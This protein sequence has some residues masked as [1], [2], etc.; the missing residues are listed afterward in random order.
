M[1]LLL[2]NF[3]YPDSICRPPAGIHPCEAVVVKPSIYKA[4]VRIVTSA[5]E[6]RPSWFRLKYC[7]ILDYV[8]RTVFER[9]SGLETV[10]AVAFTRD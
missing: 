4:T 7:A 9:Y 3:A 5:K 8:C 6:H 2:R 1:L 10:G